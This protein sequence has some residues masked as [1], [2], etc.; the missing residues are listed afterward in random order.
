MYICVCVYVCVYIYIIEAILMNT[1]N[2]PFSIL[3]R[4]ITTNYPKSKAIEVIFQGT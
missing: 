1:H 2:I 3:R 4:K